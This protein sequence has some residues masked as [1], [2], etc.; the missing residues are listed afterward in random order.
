MTILNVQPS[1]NLL[2]PMPQMSIPSS[3]H[4]VFQVASR[5]TMTTQKPKH[6]EFVSEPLEPTPGTLDA[7][8]MSRG[9][10][11]LPGRFKWRDEEYIVGRV[12]SKWKSTGTDRGEV[13]LRR[14]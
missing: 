1:S 4:F 3:L 12:M 7:A 5:S 2:L 11:G 9:E 8:A 13:Y 6:E 10:P 14:H